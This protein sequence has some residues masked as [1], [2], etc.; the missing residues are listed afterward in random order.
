MKRELDGLLEALDKLKLNNGLII[1]H[2]Q[3][4][5]LNVNGKKILVKPAWKWMLE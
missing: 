3:E 1:T 4:D 5:E 2:D